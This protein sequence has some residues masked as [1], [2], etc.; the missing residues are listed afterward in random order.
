M[1]NLKKMLV[2]AIVV[3]L[4]GAAGAAYAAAAAKTTAEIVSDLTGKTTS[5]LY[6]ER[7]AGKTYGAI[8][9]EAGQLEQFKAQ[10]L[11]Q[12]KIILDQRVSEGRLTQEQADNIY[13]TIQSRQ[14]NCDGTGNAGMCG[15]YGA[16]F[17]KGQGMGL[18][19][20]MGR[21]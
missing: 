5:E 19:N 10:M 4:M 7:S 3:G 20:G 1:K 14:A 8:A 18:G 13:K 17:G 15:N 11:E 21:Q 16:G 6:Q 2:V 9:N 12:K